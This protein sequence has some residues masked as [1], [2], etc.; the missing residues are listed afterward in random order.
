MLRF[1]KIKKKKLK[2]HKDA[3]IRELENS[4]SKK[5]GLNVNIKNN[6]R[7]KGSITFEYKEIDQLNKIIDIIKSNY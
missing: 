3:N 1:L 5:I 2:D 4:I 7:N 6:K